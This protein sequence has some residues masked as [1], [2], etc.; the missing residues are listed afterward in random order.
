MW[1][2]TIFLI[3]NGKPKEHYSFAFKYTGKLPIE[4]V[5]VGCAC[6]NVRYSFDTDGV[7]VSGMYKTPEFPPVLKD[8][9]HRSTLT[10]QMITVHLQ[11]KTEMYLTVQARIHV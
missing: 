9:G 3:D 11:D 10:S 2:K 1:D 8:A 5:S 4:G 7:V 6:T